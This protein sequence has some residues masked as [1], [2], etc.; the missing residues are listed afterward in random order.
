MRMAGVVL[1]ALFLLV[2]FALGG[3][4]SSR[5]DT[6]KVVVPVAPAATTLG[7]ELQDLED[8]Y[9]R[10]TITETEYETAKKRLIEQRTAK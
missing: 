5:S 10:G 9:K 1:L 4:C 8:A 2:V 3:C 6:E 7:Q